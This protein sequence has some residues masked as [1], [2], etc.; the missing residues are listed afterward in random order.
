M[1]V[2]ALAVCLLCGHNLT[3]A[4]FNMVY[5]H[6]QLQVFCSGHNLTVVTCNVI[7]NRAQLHVFCGHNLTTAVTISL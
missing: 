3:V 2:G 5:D 6:A 4:T 7:F 1:D